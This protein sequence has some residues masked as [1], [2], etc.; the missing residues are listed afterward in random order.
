MRCPSCGSYQ[1][2]TVDSRP[3]DAEIRRRKECPD[4]LKRFNTIEIP[5][6]EYKSLKQKS[7]ELIALC[8]EF[9]ERAAWLRIKYDK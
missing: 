2:R 8:K 9:E 6:E 1:V 4:C 5:L 3:Y 7:A